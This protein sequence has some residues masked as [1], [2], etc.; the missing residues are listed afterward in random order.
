MKE[1]TPRYIILVERKIKN[2]D[3]TVDVNEGDAAI[4]VS[5]NLDSGWVIIITDK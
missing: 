4:Y 2:V 3:G 5:P 1:V